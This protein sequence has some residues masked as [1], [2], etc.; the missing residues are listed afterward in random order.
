VVAKEGTKRGRC[1]FKQH[2]SLRIEI[3]AVMK[4]NSVLVYVERP[5]TDDT[6]LLLMRRSR[7]YS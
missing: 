4:L 6:M 1:F 5:T 7:A 2:S 3:D